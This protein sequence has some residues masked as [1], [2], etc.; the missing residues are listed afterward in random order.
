MILIFVLVGA[1]EFDGDGGDITITYKFYLYS[2]SNLA[3]ISVGKVFDGRIK[4]FIGLAILGDEGTF[5]GIF[6]V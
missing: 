4:M 2:M 3:I 1:A 5:V 6:W